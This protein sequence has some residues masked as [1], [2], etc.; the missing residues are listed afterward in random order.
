MN[1]PVLVMMT[2]GHSSNGQRLLTV[3]GNP[4]AHVP[5]CVICGCS[6]VDPNPPDLT[7]RLARCHYYGKKPR[8]GECNYDCGLRWVTVIDEHTCGPCREMNGKKLRFHDRPWHRPP[9]DE[10]ESPGCRCTQVLA[11]CSCERP[12]SPLLPFFKHHE[13]RERDEFYCGCHS[14]N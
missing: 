7:S 9:H 2:C 5:A 14:W 11:D 13:D 8:H 12:S 4:P 10:C 3:P 1:E 6:E